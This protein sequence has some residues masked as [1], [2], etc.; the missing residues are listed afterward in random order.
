MKMGKCDQLSGEKA[1][2]GGAGFW[3]IYR[4]VRGGWSSGAE[5]GLTWMCREYIC[6]QNGGLNLNEFRI[7]G[8]VLRWAAKRTLIKRYMVMYVMALKLGVTDCG[9]GEH[10][11]RH[12]FPVIRAKNLSVRF[13]KR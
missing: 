10:G 7:S 11:N 9:V 6:H 4:D 13:R 1:E 5:Y 8:S 3:A 12:H 2:G